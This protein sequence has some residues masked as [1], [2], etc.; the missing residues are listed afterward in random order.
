MARLQRGTS[1][2]NHDSRCTISKTLPRE[3]GG[4]S[5]LC[6]PSLDVQRDLAPLASVRPLLTWEGLHPA[7]ALDGGR[8]AHPVTLRATVPPDKREGARVVAAWALPPLGRC[9]VVEL[10]AEGFEAVSGDQVGAA[11]AAG[12]EAAALQFAEE[13]QVAGGQAPAFAA[14]AFG[15]GKGAAVGAFELDLAALGQGV[16]R[17]LLRFGNVQ[18]KAF[19]DQ[20]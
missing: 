3:C 1:A 4:R 10:G 8:L 15:G 19:E 7:K 12:D 6:T 14:E 9:A 11:G 13:I 16:E 17:A 18:G 20:A 2:R 5:N